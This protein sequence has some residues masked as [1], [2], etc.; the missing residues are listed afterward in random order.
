[1]S[2][3]QE[4]QNPLIG[5]DSLEIRKVIDGEEIQGPYFNRDDGS[6]SIFY[7]PDEAGDFAFYSNP[8]SNYYVNSSG[9]GHAQNIASGFSMK[10]L[11]TENNQVKADFYVND[12]TITGSKTLT[13][14]KWYFHNSLNVVG[15]LTIL[16]GTEIQFRNGAS[17]IVNGTLQAQGTHQQQITF[18]FVKS[19][20]W[21]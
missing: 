18:D 13:V 19:V 2:K 15:T 7:T 8:N 5:R 17:L 12:L 14:G 3:I 21:N 20:K 11:R 9:E 4:V 1:M 6:A 10:N 16:P